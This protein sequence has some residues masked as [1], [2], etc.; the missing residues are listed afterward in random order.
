MTKVVL[1]HGA[2]HGAWCWDGVVAELQQR[3]V[4]ATA[5]ELPLTGFA[6]D[7]AAARSAIQ[8]A[9]SHAIVV[10]HSYGGRV[11]TQAAT[12]LPVARLVY[13]AAYLGDPREAD[14]P[15]IS[16]LLAASLLFDGLE[17]RVD[18]QA[19]AAVFYGDTDAQAATA[20]VARLRPM[21]LEQPSVSDTEPAWRLTPSIY[22]VC[23]NDQALPPVSQREMAAHASEVVEW[24]TDHSPFL[25]RPAELAELI[26]RGTPDGRGRR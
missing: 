21:P 10:G 22:L 19:A 24:P 18:P 20:W 3:G 15:A 11:I 9:G 17:M 2:W 26:V 8:A 23:T 4:E 16:S 14:V 5:V 1:I 13:V 12:G 25:T 7:L 6:A